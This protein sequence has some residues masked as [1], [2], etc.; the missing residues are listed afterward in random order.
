MSNSPLVTYKKPSPNHSGI[1]KQK[2]D[3]ITPHCVVGHLSL[4]TLGNI[5]AQPARRASSNYGIDDKGKVGMYVEE[6]NRS[7][8]TS[9]SS[10]DHRAITIE[11]ASDT[12]APHKITDGAMQGLVDLSVDIC[13]RNNIPQLLWKADKS[14]VG[15][16]DK[17]N[18]T[19][20]RWFSN[21]LCPGEYILSQ[22]GYV[23]DEV[24]KILLR[25][26]EVPPKKEIIVPSKN[27]ITPSVGGVHTVKITAKSLNYR[28][29][30]GVN[31]PVLGLVRR[32]EVYTIVEEV[33][34]HGGSKW[35]KL[36]SGAGWISLSY[37]VRI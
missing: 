8:C 26:P 36:K 35:G 22:L 32:D 31:Y 18:I 24:N 13:K 25:K 4:Q 37:T 16:I 34:G 33:T 7:W 6:K 30:P 10:N 3:T 27:I 1:R 21:T 19:V 17:Q 11:V 20:H 12:T 2:I 9:S 23:A 14:L 5:F 15:K 29:G 28:R